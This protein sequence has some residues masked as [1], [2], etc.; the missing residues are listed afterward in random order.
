MISLLAVLHARHGSVPS[1]GAWTRLSHQDAPHNSA[2][3]PAHHAEQ[4]G[5]T[6]RNIARVWLRFTRSFGGVFETEQHCCCWWGLGGDNLVLFLLSCVQ[7]QVHTYIIMSI[8]KAPF[9]QPPSPRSRRYSGNVYAD[10]LCRSGGQH[11]D[12]LSWACHLKQ[13]L[14]RRSV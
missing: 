8:F 2:R 12:S 4:R 6:G 10:S 11:D 5:G 14:A 9:L 7:W 13:R 1:Q 3:A